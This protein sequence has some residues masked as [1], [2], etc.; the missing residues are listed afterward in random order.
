M[1]LNIWSEI[2]N[3]IDALQYNFNVLYFIQYL[4]ILQN[5]VDFSIIY[6]FIYMVYI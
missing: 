1:R 6:L 2:F 4:R 5:A 3:F